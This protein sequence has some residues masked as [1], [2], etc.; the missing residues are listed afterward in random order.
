M[1]SKPA[2][3]MRELEEETADLLPS[4]ETLMVIRVNLSHGGGNGCG[5]GHHHHPHHHHHHHHRGH[6][7]GW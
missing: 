6:R 1:I 7:G 4:R 2:V 3:S 5:G